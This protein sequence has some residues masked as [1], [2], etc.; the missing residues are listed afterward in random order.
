MLFSWIT[1]NWK[2]NKLLINLP[3]D[4][5]VDFIMLSYN[6]YPDFIMLSYNVHPD[7]IMLSYNVYPDCPS[8]YYYIRFG[9]YSVFVS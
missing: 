2:I 3:T 5:C 1:R 8:M 7:F 6:V 4:I 9:T